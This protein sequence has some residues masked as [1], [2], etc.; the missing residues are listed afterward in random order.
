ML[1]RL[2]EMKP[3]QSRERGDSSAQWI[4]LK[5]MKKQTDISALPYDVMSMIFEHVKGH[6][7]KTYQ[8]SLPLVNKR[9]NRYVKLKG[10]AL[11]KRPL[12]RSI[13]LMLS[14]YLVVTER[15]QNFRDLVPYR[16]QQRESNITRLLH[17]IDIGLTNG[18]IIALLFK[19]NNL[20]NH[21]NTAQA[22]VLDKV[23][24]KIFNSLNLDE[25]Q[26]F[27]QEY[28][29]SNH[30]VGAYPGPGY[31]LAFVERLLHHLF[32]AEKATLTHKMFVNDCFLT[33]FE[34]GNY[35]PDDSR[36]SELGETIRKLAT[37][38]DNEPEYGAKLHMQLARYH[39]C[40]PYT[41][42]VVII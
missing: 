41:P 28:L 18:D 42:P 23:F 39:R 21:S 4:E 9:W 32:N 38:Y 16:K 24:A 31:E 13:E 25:M 3:K 17:A 40:V 5:E 1:N 26:K 36:L 34:Q 20:I 10:E 6:N 35:S 14:K 11:Q 7:L 12:Y 33:G 8:A 2:I 22:E 37:E 19:L 30:K 27:I 29:A 15:T